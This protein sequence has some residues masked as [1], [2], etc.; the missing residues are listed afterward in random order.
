MSF[1]NRVELLL[2]SNSTIFVTELTPAIQK[3]NH[4][5]LTIYFNA[6]FNNSQALSGTK[7]IIKNRPAEKP[8]SVH[9]E[10]R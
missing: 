6:F 4:S 8:Q 7:S 3:Q 2:N 1:Y 10:K 5:S 9:G